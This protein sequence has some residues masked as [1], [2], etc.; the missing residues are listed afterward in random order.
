MIVA[1]KGKLDLGHFCSEK[2]NPGLNLLFQIVFFRFFTRLKIQKMYKPEKSC[3]DL[4]Q[5]FA[6]TIFPI[7]TNL[8][9][10]YAEDKGRQAIE[11]FFLQ[12]FCKNTWAL[13]ATSS[14]IREAMFQ[15]EDLMHEIFGFLVKETPHVLSSLHSGLHKDRAEFDRICTEFIQKQIEQ[16][17]V[18]QTAGVV[19]LKR[20][21][22]FSLPSQRAEPIQRKSEEN[23]TPKVRRWTIE[24]LISKY[25]ESVFTEQ[26]KGKSGVSCMRFL[27][28]LYG[29]KGPRCNTSCTFKHA[30][31]YDFGLP[32]GF[33]YQENGDNCT[34]YWRKLNT[35]TFVI[36]KFETADIDNFVG[37]QTT[38]IPI[39]KALSFQQVPQG[40]ID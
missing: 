9:R 13:L 1:A 23:Q 12:K 22:E 29:I 17:A 30:L 16:S 38:C 35:R 4:N 19:I 37:G 7:S 2:R 5:L 33:K 3:D 8:C 36:F 40:L 32:I 14:D 25:G 10:L 28:E 6:K 34:Y 11:T 20:P 15:H 24:T 18:K 27:F 21:A 39:G 26:G 31:D